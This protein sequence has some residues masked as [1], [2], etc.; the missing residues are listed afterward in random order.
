MGRAHPRTVRARAER[1]REQGLTAHEIAKRLRLPWK[2]VQNWIGGRSERAYRRRVDPDVARSLVGQG[3]TLREI[4]ERF[5]V[6]A[7]AVCKAIKRTC[8]AREFLDDWCPAHLQA[9]YRSLRLKLGRAAE[10]RRVII[11]HIE[12]GC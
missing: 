12:R 7:P 3:L 6:S 4:G 11:A 9:D 5:G 8:P 1:L 10:A 2:T